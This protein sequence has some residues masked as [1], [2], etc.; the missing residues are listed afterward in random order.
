MKNILTHPK[1][2]VAG[3][4]G[5]FCAVSSMGALAFD[6]L[7]FLHNRKACDDGLANRVLFDK[8]PSHGQPTYDH[9]REQC[10]YKYTD[11]QG[12]EKT[13]IWSP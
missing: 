6:H 1:F 13:L 4:I 11:G 5:A 8:L 3:V 9:S 12:Q 7:T 2:A 10:V